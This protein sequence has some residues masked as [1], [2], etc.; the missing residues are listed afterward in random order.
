MVLCKSD[1]TVLSAYFFAFSTPRKVPAIARFQNQELKLSLSSITEGLTLLW[2]LLLLS[3]R[4]KNV[5]QVVFTSMFP[6][7]CGDLRRHGLR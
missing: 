5:A 6:S 1:L 4:F 7:N 3:L 2:L